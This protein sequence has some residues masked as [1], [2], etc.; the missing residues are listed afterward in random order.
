MFLDVESMSV[1]MKAYRTLLRNSWVPGTLL[2]SLQQQWLKE[3]AVGEGE[4]IS[5]P[6]FTIIRG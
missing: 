4:K 6:I 2:E 5:M 1:R 3:D